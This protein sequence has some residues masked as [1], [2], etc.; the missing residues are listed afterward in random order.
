MY[1]KFS[2]RFA[3]PSEKLR[4]ASVDETT[5]SKIAELARVA[6]E[7][8]DLVPLTRDLDAIIGFVEQMNS[9]DTEGVE[10]MAHPLEV[11]QRL[12]ADEITDNSPRELYQA[13]APSHE[14][15]LYLVPRVLD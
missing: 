12:R 8:T 6:V 1:V 5:L 7:D 13:V 15:G 2:G 9:V 3:F 14:A 4:M 10:P 11:A